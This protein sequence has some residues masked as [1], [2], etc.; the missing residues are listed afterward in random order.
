MLKRSH[1]KKSKLGFT[2]RLRSRSDGM[3]SF[4]VN[5][6]ISVDSTDNTDNDNDNDNDSV[7]TID[8][9]PNIAIGSNSN[10]S[11]PKKMKIKLSKHYDASTT[12]NSRTP[13]AVNTHK[14]VHNK[15]AFS[16]QK[17]KN[18]SEP[19]GPYNNSINNNYHHHRH[20]IFSKKRTS[21]SISIGNRS[22]P[23]SIATNKIKSRFDVDF[24]PNMDYQQSTELFDNDTTNLFDDEANFEME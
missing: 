24:K 18:K 9:T 13:P 14:Y 17:R 11:T 1:H 6:S 7:S 3:L 4:S 10:S 22:K 16:V 5:K 21:S 2:H 19:T 15:S 12:I 20:H 8:S 23:L